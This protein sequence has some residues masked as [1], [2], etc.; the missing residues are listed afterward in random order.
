[1]RLKNPDC[2]FENLPHAVINN[3]SFQEWVKKKR[4]RGWHRHARETH[5]DK[6]PL[7]KRTRVKTPGSLPS[8]QWRSE[9]Q[10]PG[11]VL[12]AGTQ[13]RRAGEEVF[14]LSSPSWYRYL[15]KCGDQGQKNEAWPITQVCLQLCVC[16]HS[17]W[18]FDHSSDN[19]T[20]DKKEKRCSVQQRHSPKRDGTALS[21]PVC[22]WSSLCSHL[23]S[24][25]RLEPLSRSLA[26]L[27]IKELPGLPWWLRW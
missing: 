22:L 5:E 3:R 17:W 11:S 26:L 7:L 12:Q 6:V 16:L 23:E 4:G 13:R 24:L 1:M 15:Q 25:A 19:V 8:R 18:S 20:V 14:T 21:F 9:V 2:W 10:I 27:E